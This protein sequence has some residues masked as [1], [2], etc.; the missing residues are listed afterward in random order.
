MAFINYNG[1]I[2]DSAE[3]IAVVGNRGLRYG[4][5]VFETIKMLN[6]EIIFEADHLN[7]LW[8]GL[9]VLQFE[10]PKHFSKEALVM[11]IK[12]LAKKNYCEKAARIRVNIFR[13]NGGLYDPINHF[14]NCVIEA[15]AL[16]TNS[17]GLNNNGL[18]AGFFTEAFKSCD[19]LANLKHNN[20]LVYALAAIGAKK[21]KWN[22]S[23]ILNNHG[24]IADSTIANIFMVKDGEILTPALEEGCIAG[25]MRKNLISFLHLNKWAVKE[26]AITK[27]I[28]LQADEIFFTN[29]IYD[30]RWVKQIENSS[31]TNSITKK[32]Y[33][34]FVPTIY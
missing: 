31:F 7:R 16:T 28:L 13:G 10:L 21:E 15:V 27:E 3:P 18:V 29:S 1:K 34:D 20:F 12:E 9:A 32:I 19:S 17:D 25:V 11:S 6:G 23:I 30:I 2:L 22:D 14:P 33:T 5:G 24:R 4:D 26:T 8:N